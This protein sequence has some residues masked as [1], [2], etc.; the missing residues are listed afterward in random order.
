MVAFLRRLALAESPS[1]VPASQA[2]VQAILT[3][4]LEA[5]GFAVNHLAGSD[6]GGHL[7]ARAA[8]GAGSGRQQLLLGHSDTVWP[9]G[10]VEEMP[11][12]VRGRKVVGPGVYDMKAGLTQMIF[13]LRALHEL[14]LEMPVAPAVFVNSDEEI[15]SPEAT[16]YLQRLAP[17][18]ARVFVVEPSLGP[19]GRLK[20]ARKGVGRFHVVAHGRAAHAG[21]DPEKGRSAILELSHVIRKLFALNDVATGVTVNVGVV[22]GGVR[23]NVIAP[24]AEAE[25]DV[26]VPTQE[27][28]QRVEAAIHRVEPEVPGVTL[29]ITGQISRPP[30]LPTPRNRALWQL[31]LRSAQALGLTLEE[32][33]AGGG[34]DGNT[35]SQF[36][37]TLDGLGAVGDGAHARDEFVY[38]D[39]MAE[40]AA[41]LALLLLAPPLPDPDG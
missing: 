31:A 41:L 4:A 29:Q 36:T 19:R 25:I 38:I 6:S 37:A 12:E 15:G 8:A 10:T 23:S 14:H 35:T 32:G 18:M 24:K 5:L 2:A 34:S 3:E 22:Q 27:D 16:S 26:R 39:K 9:L 28:A 33:T 7:Y 30:L 11:V 13:A 17:Q 40:R 20:T 21:L 1:T